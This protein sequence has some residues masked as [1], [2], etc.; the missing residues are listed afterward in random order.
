MLRIRTMLN[1]TLDIVFCKY[2]L[3]CMYDK[4]YMNYCYSK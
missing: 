2:E 1:H 4:G 3:K